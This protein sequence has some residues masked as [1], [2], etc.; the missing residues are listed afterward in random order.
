MC[1][2]TLSPRTSK[3]SPRATR[4]T[5]RLR[6][7][8]KALSHPP[9]KSPAH[10]RRAS[11]AGGSMTLIRR[12]CLT[13]ALYFADMCL[14]LRILYQR[15]CQCLLR[16]GVTWCALWCS[17]ACMRADCQSHRQDTAQCL[18]KPVHGLAARA[19]PVRVDSQSDKLSSVSTSTVARA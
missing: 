7:H 19:E 11:S 6:I 10:T 1:G 4:L 2:R 13:A 16:F 14:L 5:S 12:I 3:P 15:M 8:Y 18:F 17:F 9:T